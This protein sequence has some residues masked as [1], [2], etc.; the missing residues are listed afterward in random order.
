M[1]DWPLQQ[2]AAENGR[3]HQH[4]DLQLIERQSLPEHRGHAPERTVDDAGG[5][6]A[7]RAQRRN[8]KQILEMHTLDE[9]DTRLGD[10]SDCDRHDAEGDQHARQGK[11]HQ[12]AGIA[13][14]QQ[15]LPAPQRDQGA[16]H[17]NGED[18]T[19]RTTFTLFVQPAL[20]D[21]VD[22]NDADTIDHTQQEP[23]QGI[24]QQTE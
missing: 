17:V 5:Q 20:D 3:T 1:T 22:A 10:T 11:Q 9:F 8:T 2:S 7:D 23:G 6:C 14:Q 4:R 24:H 21:H 12:L 15:E 16:H 13:R 19:A 18:A